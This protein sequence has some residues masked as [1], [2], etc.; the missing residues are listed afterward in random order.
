MKDQDTEKFKSL[1]HWW[2][3]LKTQINGKEFRVQGLKE[4]TVLKCPY[5]SNNSRFS[6]I[7][8]NISMA[9]FTEIEPTFLKSV[10][11]HKRSWKVHSLLRRT[12]LKAEHLFISNYKTKL[13]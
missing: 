5:Y 3:K 8:V 13:Q 7:P 6:A 11:T 10:S 9:F 2:K 4:L 12:K 1:R